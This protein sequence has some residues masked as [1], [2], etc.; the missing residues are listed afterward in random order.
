MSLPIARP[1]SHVQQDSARIEW[2]HRNRTQLDLVTSSGTASNHVV[3]NTPLQ[4]NTVYNGTVIATDADGN[5][6]D[7]RFPSFNTWLTAPNNI[8]IES[9]DYN[10]QERSLDQ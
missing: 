4:A 7:Q 8:Y 5:S 2:R 9:G 1:R 6:S 10:F 3:L